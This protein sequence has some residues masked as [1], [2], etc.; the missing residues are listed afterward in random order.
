M[1]RSALLLALALAACRGTPPDADPQVMLDRLVD[2]LAPAVERAT[3]LEFR[4]RPQVTLR[5][6]DEVRGFILAKVAEEFPA[7]RVRGV[8]TAYRLLGLIPDTLD[9]EAL[10]LDLYT[11]QVAGFYDPDSTV[12]YAVEGADPAQTRLVIA[13]ELVHALQDQYLPLDSLLSERRSSDRT[14]AAQAVLEGHATIASLQVLVPGQGILDA[15]DFWQNFRLQIRQS[16]ETMEVF[17]RAP[18]A[19]REGLIFPY[20]SGSDFMR[21]WAAARAGQ[22]LPTVDELPRSTEQVLHPERYHAGDQPLEVIFTDSTGTVLYE[23]TLGEIELHILAAQ[24][25]GGEMTTTLAAGWGGDRLRVYEAPEGP[26]LVWWKVWD[27]D[28]AARRFRVVT[29]QR[30]VEQARAGYRT[31]VDSTSVDG[32]PAVRTVIA[33]TGWAGWEAVPGVRL[34]G[35]R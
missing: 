35:G 21:W 16:Q 26:A 33:P 6:R 25:R 11:E 3:G 31:A 10:L 30:L 20:L 23:D 13:H 19:L 7:E 1:P 22:P 27:S 15:P 24:L 28:V 17:Q 8:T 12:L 9:L 18:L 29:G 32:R 4:E 14:V 2:S 34:E 5:T